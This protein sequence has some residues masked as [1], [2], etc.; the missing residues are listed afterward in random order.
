MRHDPSAGF[1]FLNHF[2]VAGNEYVT[3]E[4]IEL[5]MK[6][7]KSLVTGGNYAIK[8]HQGNT[9]AQIKGSTMTT[10]NTRKVYSADGSVMITLHEKKVTTRPTW[11]AFKGDSTKDADKLCEFKIQRKDLDDIDINF[12]GRL[13]NILP[14]TKISGGI[15]NSEY[16]IK[17]RKALLFRKTLAKVS[18]TFTMPGANA[19]A[20]KDVYAI[21]ISKG[22]DFAF[23]LA[24][25][26]AAD[27]I[28]NGMPTA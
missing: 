7:A 4:P 6:T 3:S 10:R 19:G 9:V 25:A 8:D 12:M 2:G 11:S 28:F 22:V 18:R 26:L 17:A 1:A 27:M 16:T 14:H 13:A 21:H 15:N 23:I 24:A 5:A 20:D